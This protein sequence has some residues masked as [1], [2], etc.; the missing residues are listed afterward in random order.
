M[1]NRKADVRAEIAA[2]LA[3]VDRTRTP[4]HL[5][6]ELETLQTL[7]R[8]HFATEED[9]EGFRSVFDRSAPHLLPAME[10]FFEEHRQFLGDLEGLIEAARA[11]SA[12]PLADLRKGVSA[13]ATRL[14][15]HE[16]QED[17]LFMDSVYTDL[18]GGD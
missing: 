11:L 8:T 16:V 3:S 4:D 18:G 9:G 17:R 15:A 13:L 12:D 14:Q 10:R 7:L 6:T 2:Q 5:V 1:R